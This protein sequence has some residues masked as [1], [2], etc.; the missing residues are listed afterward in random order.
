MINVQYGPVLTSFLGNIGNLFAI[1][2]DK[3]SND[4]IRNSKGFKGKLFEY[5]ISLF[6]FEIIPEKVAIYLVNWAI[7][8]VYL[9]MRYRR[10]KMP[11]V[12]PVR[13]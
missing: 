8:I 1:K 2:T 9:Y 6:I 5:G 12:K 3:I 10:M 11:T 7:W 13:H 4:I